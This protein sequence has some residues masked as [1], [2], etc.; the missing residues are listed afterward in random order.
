VLHINFVAVLACSRIVNSGVAVV[1]SGGVIFGTIGAR[2]WLGALDYRSYGAGEVFVF[3][4]QIRTAMCIEDGCYGRFKPDQM[5]QAGHHGIYSSSPSSGDR[6]SI[7]DGVIWE[8]STLPQNK[9]SKQDRSVGS[10]RNS[11]QCRLSVE[12]V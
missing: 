8:L 5:D 7:S 3:L 2:A 12:S 10:L 4:H 11:F 9:S 1:I 6:L